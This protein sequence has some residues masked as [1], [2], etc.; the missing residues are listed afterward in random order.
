MRAGTRTIAWILVAHTATK[1][2]S[3]RI[4]F[5]FVGRAIAWHRPAATASR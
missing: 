4:W 3:I 5:R 2:T 1:A